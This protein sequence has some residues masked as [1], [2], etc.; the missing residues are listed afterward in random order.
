MWVCVQESAEAS[1]G[2]RT[3][4]LELE[5]QAT[6]IHSVCMLEIKSRTLSYLL[7]PSSGPQNQTLLKALQG[8]QTPHPGLLPL[9]L[10]VGSFAARGCHV[11]SSS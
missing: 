9:L 10:C 4:T 8:L 3:D 6:V 1:G 2:Q 5:L 11:N 7:S